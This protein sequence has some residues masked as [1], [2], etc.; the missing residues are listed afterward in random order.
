MYGF[1]KKPILI[2][3]F[4]LI[5][6]LP[7]FG[8]TIAP[9]VMPSARSGAMGGTHAALADDF[10]SLFTN[11]AAF[12]GVK[13][14]FSAGEISVSM[15]GPVFELFDFIG[16][17]SGSDL[18]TIDI[19]GLLGPRGF[20]TGFDIGGPVSVGWVGRGLGVGLFNR[21]KVEAALSGTTLRP[22]AG[23]EIIL[24]G[25]YSF[26]LLNNQSHILDVG[27][28]GKGFFRGLV[29]M[30]ASIF[31]IED[32][33]SD[34]M[35]RPFRT[36]LGVGL[37][38]GLRYTFANA[39]SAALV[40]YDVYSPAL[41]NTY[42][43]IDDFFN[44]GAPVD[45][46]GY[47]TVTRRLDLGLMYRIRSPLLHRYITNFSIM[48][49]YQDF[50]DLFSLIPRNPI[51]N[52]GIGAELVILNA[53]SLRAGIADA[54]PSIGFGLDLTFMK[55]DFAIRGKEL[56]IEPGMNPTYGVD[57]GLLFRY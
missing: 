33:L 1:L 16:D 46:G 23:E 36:Q 22:M 24:V 39:L 18:S 8:E 27:F 19:S 15:Y 6:K 9:F 53:L 26:R 57:L 34:P 55:I 38:L 2:L 10:Y 30:S 12:V 28:L 40:C 48:V 20:T 31:E 50:M 11:P 52:V 29:D 54:L 32:L 49:D 17:I 25:G 41:V 44:K 37:D 42:K 13:E 3:F 51:L 45:S 5:L 21:T 43:T 56:G 7:G 47:A 4:V 35:A 14:Q